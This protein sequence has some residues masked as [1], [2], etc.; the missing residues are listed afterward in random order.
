MR[1]RLWWMA[2]A[3]LLGST[4]LGAGELSY[5][6]PG[7]T[8]G[9][10]RVRGADDRVREVLPGEMVADAGELRRV[11]EDEVVFERRLGSDE[12]EALRAL[13][14]S[15]PDVERLHVPRRPEAPR[16]AEADPASEAVW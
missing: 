8:P 6:G 4:G 10:A 5:L 13:G 14:L 15:V 1:R 12:R 7:R 2:L 11:T 16:A 3:L 9:S